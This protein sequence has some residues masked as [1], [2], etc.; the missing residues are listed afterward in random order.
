M[1]DRGG[2]HRVVE[3]IVELGLA[4]LGQLQVEVG[5][6][7]GE[8]VVV[9]HLAQ[10]RVAEAVAV[11][12]VDLHHL[13]LDRFPQPGR[14]FG[15]V[16]PADGGEQGVVEPRR[17]GEHPQQRARPLRQ[18]F[19]PQQQR[20]AQGGGEAA[21]TVGAGREQL[22]GK[23]RVAFAAVE[24]ALD[25][26]GVRGGADDVGELRRHL[27][28]VERGELQPPHVAPAGQL[29]QQ[30]PH[31][32]AA[33]ELVGAVG[34]HGQQ[35]ALVRQAGGE[36]GE[37]AA[38]RVVG[39]VGVVEPEDQRRFLG[40]RL[41]QAEQPLEGAVHVVVVGERRRVGREQLRDQVREP[42]P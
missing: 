5:A 7:A 34:D 42:E 26:L 37:E 35:P 39:P 29:R 15:L 36:V 28:A 11:V 22:L 31:R 3:R 2:G 13:R 1:G 27:A 21:T 24:E 23:E 32:V 6:L 41:Q 4:R 25:H 30:R 16:D 12:G 9:D 8:Q 38:G 18:A 10:Q 17:H 20:V 40:H 14:Q 19:D 33:V